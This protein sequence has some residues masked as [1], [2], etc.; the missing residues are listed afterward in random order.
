M[1][2]QQRPTVELRELCSVLCASL[3]GRGVGGRM[4]TCMCMAESL[5]CSLETT[6]RLLIGY[7]PIQSVFGVKKK[8]KKESLVKNRKE[9]TRCVSQLFPQCQRQKQVESGC[10]NNIG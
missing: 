5:R 1:D 2:N 9:K 10:S 4:G 7:T 3:D 6:T 8:K